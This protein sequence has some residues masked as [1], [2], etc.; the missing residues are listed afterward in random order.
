MHSCLWVH[1]TP[2]HCLKCLCSTQ[3]K[4]RKPRCSCM[5]SSHFRRRMCTVSTAA[6]LG[7][8]YMHVAPG[9]CLASMCELCIPVLCFLQ[10]HCRCHCCCQD[11]CRSRMSHWSTCH[12]GHVQHLILAGPCM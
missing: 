10:Q 2:A 11:G 1:G 5:C 6:I 7:A 8:C 3:H 12:T 9:L 4:P